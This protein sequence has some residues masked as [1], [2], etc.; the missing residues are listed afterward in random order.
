MVTYGHSLKPQSARCYTDHTLCSLMQE[1]PK[2]SNLPKRIGSGLAMSRLDHQTS[3]LGYVKTSLET[4]TGYG[5]TV[6]LPSIGRHIP[7]RHVNS[8]NA[9]GC[10]RAQFRHWFGASQYSKSEHASMRF[11]KLISCEERKTL[12]ISDVRNCQALYVKMSGVYHCVTL[13]YI[14]NIHLAF[15]SQHA[16]MVCLLN[17]I[18]RQSKSR[19]AAP[20]FI[21]I[22]QRS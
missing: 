16:Q 9:W 5:F 1:V 11:W 10:I 15:V 21:P 7:W 20:N 2:T 13:R 12:H 18:N 3:S 4:P 14:F 22:R 6:G 17:S 19:W 8:P